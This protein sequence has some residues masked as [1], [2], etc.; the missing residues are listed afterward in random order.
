MSK[1]E[2][3][4]DYLRARGLSEQEILVYSTVLG[5]GSAT[6]GEINLAIKM[7]LPEIYVQMKQLEEIGYIKQIPGIVPRYIAMEPFLKDYAQLTSE[8]KLGLIKIKDNFQA[9]AGKF[10]QKIKEIVPELADFCERE[11]NAK[12]DESIAFGFELNKAT[13]SEIQIVSS[14][15]DASIS[16]MSVAL[17]SRTS[18]L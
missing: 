7:E 16:R 2:V 10:T 1:K 11:K 18:P 17:S 9:Q 14:K 5:L 12:I 15:S 4:S 6:I 8:V 3:S 13:S